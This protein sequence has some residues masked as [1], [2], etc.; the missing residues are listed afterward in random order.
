MGRAGIHKHLRLNQPGLANTS[1]NLSTCGLLSPL[2]WLYLKYVLI[3][4]DW[5]KVEYFCYKS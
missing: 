2:W 4:S 3:R 5:L 1:A